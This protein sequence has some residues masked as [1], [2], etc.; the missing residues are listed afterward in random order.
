VLALCGA[1]WYAWRNPPDEA[2]KSARPAPSASRPVAVPPP[3]S[4]TAARATRR[5]QA[6]MAGLK[7]FAHQEGYST[8]YGFLADMS[9]PGGRKRFFVADLQ[10]DTVL[11]AGLVAHGSCRED[12]LEEARFGNT[13]GCGCSSPGKYRVGASYPG[14]FGTAWKLHGLDSSNSNAFRRYVVLHAYDCVPDEEIYPMALCN[15]LGCPMVSYTFLET[16]AGY[17]R[18]EQKPILLWVYR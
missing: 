10:T 2:T 1:G 4:A 11:A 15:S 9:L 17:I 3:V 5:L 16:I 14:R 18:R 12:F 8:R 7:A 6:H 13:V